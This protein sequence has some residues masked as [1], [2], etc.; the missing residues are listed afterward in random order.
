MTIEYINV[1][2]S[3]LINERACYKNL[4]P[5]SASSDDKRLLSGRI[6]NYRYALRHGLYISMKVK[7]LM[8]ETAGVIVNTQYYSRNE[9]IDFALFMR[10]QSVLSK[11]DLNYS[12]EKWELLRGN[13]SD[14]DSK[15]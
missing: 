6:R 7:I 10:K 15:S 11:S 2:F 3:R 1:E 13:K 5:A 8:L 14:S 4:L 12:L 9:L